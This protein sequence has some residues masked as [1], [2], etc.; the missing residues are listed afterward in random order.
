MDELTLFGIHAPAEKR[1]PNPSVAYTRDHAQVEG[2]IPSVTHAKAV[3]VALGVLR[4]HHD[5]R[6][7]HHD[8]DLVVIRLNFWPF[9]DVLLPIRVRQVELPTS[10]VQAL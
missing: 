9:G 2:L 3:I 5:V 1:R 6:L 8:W 7:R 10:V 4:L